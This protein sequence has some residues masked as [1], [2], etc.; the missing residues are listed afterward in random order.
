VPYTPRDTTSL[1]QSLAARVVARTELTDLS[2]GSVLMHLLATVAEELG[3]SELRLKQIR[4]SYFLRTTTGAELDER[5]R[6]LPPGGLQRRTPTRAQGAVV[7][8]TRVNEA[9]GADDDYPDPL[10]LPAG[11]VFRRSDDP[12]QTYITTADVVFAGSP[13]SGV[14]GESTKT[15]VY[16]RAANAGVQ[17]NCAIGAIKEIVTA[18]ASIISV[19][20]TIALDN[21]NDR[22][23]DAKLRDRM[24]VYMASLARCQPAALEFAALDFE[25]S[26]GGRAMYAKVYED[27]AN[28]G[29]SE[30]VVDDGSGLE[31]NTTAGTAT[32]GDVPT[33]GQVVLYHDAPA[34]APIASIQVSR[35]GVVTTYSYRDSDYISLHER[36]LVYFPK[37]VLLPGDKWTIEGYDVYTSLV[38]EL[39]Q[40][41][42]G[43]PSRPVDYPGW[44]A[45]GTRVVVRPARTEY[46]SFDLHVVPRS[47]IALSEVAAE[48][49]TAAVEFFRG[50]A[51]GETMYVARLID[52]LMDNSKVISLR[53]YEPTTS[54]F[55]ADHPAPAYDA[56]WR[57][58]AER[59][60]I[61]PA[62][63]E[64]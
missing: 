58:S 27:P 24:L 42:E 6:E 47:Y 19:T 30:L 29:Y 31:G 15:G 48:L 10:T 12:T 40:Y 60:T 50:L 17:G 55:L 63:E 54:T 16:V 44:R 13:S 33:H 28:R 57:T 20:N 26:L 8:V 4:D 52:R 34:T 49:E 36:G 23:S 11:S 46:M 21:G 51:P 56:S 61:I 3:L 14:A 5:A 64:S 45:A 43:D 35:G 9:T 41:I 22:E 7:S 2:E 39:Q 38:S 32:T 25:S 18:P 37:G 62:I 53:V 59:I 1:L